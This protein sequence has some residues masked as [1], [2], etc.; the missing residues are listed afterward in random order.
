MGKVGNLLRFRVNRYIV[1][2]AE[3]N[4]TRT[5]AVC[6]L[7]H[8]YSLIYAILQGIAPFGTGRWHDPYRERNGELRI[9]SEDI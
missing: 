9:Y 7:M 4:S 6:G 8:V 5:N 2:G 1:P 3:E